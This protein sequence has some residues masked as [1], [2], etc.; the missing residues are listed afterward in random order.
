MSFPI[1]RGPVLSP[2]RLPPNQCSRNYKETLG[3]PPS[4]PPALLVEA[5]LE[6]HLQ[7]QSLASW[8]ACIS[9]AHLAYPSSLFLPL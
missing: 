6:G 7:R 3:L 9:R 2:C 8:A 1:I 5:F 4:P